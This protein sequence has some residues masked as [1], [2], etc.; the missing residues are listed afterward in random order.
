MQQGNQ[1]PAGR[2]QPGPTTVPCRFVCLWGALLKGGRTSWTTARFLHKTKGPR[3]PLRKAQAH[4]TILVQTQASEGKCKRPA[5]RHHVTKWRPYSHEGKCKRTPTRQ[6]VTKWRLY[7]RTF[8]DVQISRTDQTFCH[9]Q[10][11][12]NKAP[13][14]LFFVA[15]KCLWKK[16]TKASLLVAGLPSQ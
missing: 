15:Q 8:W 6:P 2:G 13:R 11:P 16:T 10:G 9:L 3:S 1:F 12:Q 4:K 5:P 7:L 14:T